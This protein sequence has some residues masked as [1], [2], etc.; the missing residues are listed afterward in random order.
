MDFLSPRSKSQSSRL[1]K[2]IERMDQ[3]TNIPRENIPDDNTLTKQ[4]IKYQLSTRINVCSASDG[5]Q[6]LNGFLVFS[7]HFPLTAF[8]QLDDPNFFPSFSLAAFFQRDDPNFSLLSF[9][10]PLFNLM[11]QLLFLFPS[12][13]L[14]S[15]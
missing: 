5:P 10:L 13:R 1:K 12:R 15:T 2:Q 3:T 14:S 8:S 4:D 11:I 6:K 7:P 9:S